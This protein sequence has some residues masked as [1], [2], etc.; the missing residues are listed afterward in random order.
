MDLLTEAALALLEDRGATALSLDEVR[1]IIEKDELDSTV[2]PAS[3]L[4]EVRREG[5]RVHLLPH[6][7][8]RW[9]QVVGPHAW[10]LVPRATADTGGGKSGTITKLRATL[11]ALGMHVEAGSMRAWARWTRML[12]EEVQ[13]RRALRR[14]TPEK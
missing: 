13:L 7:R 5:A 14:R 2:R 8:K 4:S 10:I 1:E 9:A 3:L 6:P 12:E 11:S